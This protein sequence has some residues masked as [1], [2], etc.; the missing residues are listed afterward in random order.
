MDKLKIYNSNNSQINI[1]EN[2]SFII[3][4]DNYNKKFCGIEQKNQNEI[5]KNQNIIIQN[6]QNEI[7]NIKTKMEEI[8]KNQNI[9]NGVVILRNEKSISYRPQITSQNMPISNP[10]SMQKNMENV[11]AFDNS[12]QNITRI[13]HSFV[14]SNQEKFESNCLEIYEIKL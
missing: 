7:N 12:M 13:D 14:L 1:F 8:N 5:I 11:Y 3:K 6:L 2:P 10:T 4:Y 9:R